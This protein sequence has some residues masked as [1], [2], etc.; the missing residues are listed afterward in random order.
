[1]V[2]M[3]GSRLGPYE[4]LSLAGS[5]GMGEVY[6]ARDTRL[7][8]VVA[9]KIL[10]PG[11]A[12][13]PVRLARFER[14]ARTTASLAHPHICTLHDTGRDGDCWYFVTEY[15]DGETLQSRLIRGAL[16]MEEALRYAIEIAE[17]LDY[18]HRRH[19]L[20]RDMKP[21]NIM[22]T[23]MG[24]KL[25]D[26]GLA[27]SESP[28]V[29]Q[30]EQARSDTLTLTAEGTFVGTLQYAAP[31]QLEGKPVDARTDLFAFGAVVYEMLTGRRAFAGDSAASVIAAILSSEPP[32]VATVRSGVAPALDR[33]V[34]RLLAKDPEERWQT[35]R[36]VL[37]ELKWIQKERPEP[38]RAAMTRR[39]W[40]ASTLGILV[41][42]ALAVMALWNS[43][44]EVRLANQRSVRFEIGPPPGTSFVPTLTNLSLSP[45]G[46]RLAFLASASPVG[47]E[48]VGKE[49]WIRDIESG[50]T[51]RLDGTDGALAPFWSPDSQ[52]VAFEADGKLKK[53]NLAAGFPETVVSPGGS[54][55]GGAWS[56]DGT[57][58]FHGAF[59]GP[60]FRVASGG[61]AAVAATRMDES[62][63]ELSHNWPSFLPDGRHFVFLSV[64][65]R[66]PA[67]QL[68]LAS[69]DS[70]H[71]V[72]LLEDVSN[73]VYV[74]PGYLLFTRQGALFAQP[75]DAS[76]RVLAG[77]AT[78]LAEQ[79]VRSMFGV[80]NGMSTF[81]VSANGLLAY[82]AAKDVPLTWLDRSCRVVG[83]LG[84]PGQYSHPAISPDG[85]RLAVAKLNPAT[86][87]PDVWMFDLPR[88]VGTPFTTDPGSESEPVWSPDGKQLAYFSNRR[89]HFE[90]LAK[91]SDSTTGEWQ[92]R[93][94]VI[95]VDDWSPDG[96]FIAYTSMEEN[97]AGHLALM[98]TRGD[99][100]Q[101]TTLQQVP[102]VAMANG[103]L[104]FSPDGRW[105][106][107]NG[108]ESGRWE[109]YMTAYPSGAGKWPVSTGGGIAP[110]WRRDGREFFY[111]ARDGSLMAVRISDERT[112]QSSVPQRLCASPVS[113]E[114]GA[115]ARRAP[116]DVSPDGQRFVFAAA[117]PA[118]AASGPITIVVNWPARLST[119]A[120]R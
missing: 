89:G 68:W 74:P 8:R 37:A 30:A 40:A 97:T 58:V 119:I 22:L 62:R 85:T 93:D 7:D 98:S 81:S 4:V 70:D 20:H 112:F 67:T 15:V 55:F 38:R 43:R 69:L 101:S 12:V 33:L 80:P 24:V 88:G 120:D 18:A 75:F 6:R 3:P 108:R 27:T 92:L 114:G 48:P 109:I 50:R 100:V 39:L 65:S 102:K 87:T 16:P 2:L 53:V 57:L 32:P 113:G 14:E 115:G 72:P 35:A 13:D 47:K 9:V 63:G 83:E 71:R 103:T 106:A 42:A 94:R 64:N 23:P 82:R 54:K 66:A 28:P 11:V 41:L 73:T 116:Y 17:A 1:M 76:R 21:A 60:L 86:G 117:S 5:G 19:V 51:H 99:P 44:E 111:I 45:D 36:D 31:E 56:V 91:A 52:W 29:F 61:G 90:L 59:G 26:F 25:L 105:V 78:P 34:A 118:G 95:G 84:P 107:Y 104:T 96:R 46:R 10:P 79:V 77:E 110:R 49:L